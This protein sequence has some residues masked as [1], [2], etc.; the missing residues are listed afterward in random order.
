MRDNHDGRHLVER[1][2]ENAREAGERAFSPT[3]PAIRRSYKGAGDGTK[4]LKTIPCVFQ[5]FV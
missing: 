5:Y 3:C 4:R 1:I 2:R